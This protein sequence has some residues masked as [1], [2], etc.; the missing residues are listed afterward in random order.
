MFQCLWF[1]WTLLPSANEVWCKVM[2]YTCLS[3]I[4]STEGDVMMSLPVM[5]STSL[6]DSTHPSEQY[7]QTVPITLKAP[8][9]PEI[10]HQLDSTHPLGQHPSLD[11]THYLDSTHPPGQHLPP[12]PLNST[13]NLGQ[14]SLLGEKVGSTHPTELLFCLNCSYFIPFI[15]MALILRI[16]FKF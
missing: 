4:L 3:V 2:F 13:H 12:P 6:V 10:T 11:N 5:D 1:L 15:W 14:H 9:S 8:R 16:M 7:P